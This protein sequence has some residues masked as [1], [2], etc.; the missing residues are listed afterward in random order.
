MF[1]D[2]R[3]DVAKNREELLGFMDKQLKELYPYAYQPKRMD[4]NEQPVAPK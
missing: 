1:T 2:I 4:L 3:A